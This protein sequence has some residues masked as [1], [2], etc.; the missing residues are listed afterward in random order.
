MKQRLLSEHELDARI[1]NFL[2]K[3]FAKFPELDREPNTQRVYRRTQLTF[4]K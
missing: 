2:G 3:K 4:A 1:H